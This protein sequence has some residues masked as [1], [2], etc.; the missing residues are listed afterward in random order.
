MM[1]TERASQTPGHLAA[2]DAVTGRFS[3]LPHTQVTIDDAFW[4]PRQ[5]VNRERTIPHIYVQC[6]RTGRIDA[7]RGIWDPEL[8]QRGVGGSNI[9]VLFWDSDIAKWIEAASYSL[10]THPDAQLDA[11]LDQV[12]ELVARAQ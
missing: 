10:A 5:R 7:L 12:I 8:V 2:R 1:E 3:P 9:P 6:Q 4:A 11:L